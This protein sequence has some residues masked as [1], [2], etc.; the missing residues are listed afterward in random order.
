ME[1]QSLSWDQLPDIYEVR[2]VLKQLAIHRARLR[3]A[4]LELSIA[5]ADIAKDNPRNTAAK[6]VGVSGET[7]TQLIR[8][9]SEIVSIK[10]MIDD[11]EAEEKF[12]NFRKEIVKSVSWKGRV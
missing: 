8:L 6:V 7:R 5:Q 12:L 1:D 4:E 10:N 11:L 2:G 3:E 9:Q